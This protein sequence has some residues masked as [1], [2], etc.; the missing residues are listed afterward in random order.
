MI[1]RLTCLMLL[2]LAFAAVGHAQQTPAPP[3]CPPVPF[4]LT[5]AGTSNP[6]Q[7]GTACTLWLVQYKST[8]FTAIT[9]EFDY[10][11]DG[12]A[13]PGSWAIWPGSA[14]FTNTQSGQLVVTGALPWAAVR[15]LAVS[16]SGRVSGSFMGW[17]QPPASLQP[18]T[19]VIAARPVA[20]VPVPGLPLQICN[21]VR[22]TNCQPKPF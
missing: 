5:A 19:S 1:R 4:S 7:N 17:R 21:A 18:P 2:V 14:T 11:P 15:L 20:V 16:G 12:N 13:S 6:Y 3:D 8:G 9:L 22:Q 10:A